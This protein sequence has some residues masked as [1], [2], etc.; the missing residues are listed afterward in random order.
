MVNEALR[1]AR[2]WASQQ[3]EIETSQ[4]CEIETNPAGVADTSTWT[5]GDKD[6]LVE[7]YADGSGFISFEEGEDDTKLIESNVDTDKFDV[8]PVTEEVPI[9]NVT[10]FAKK[11]TETR[12]LG[13]EI[14]LKAEGPAPTTKL[15]HQ[16]DTSKPSPSP[17]QI[18]A[19]RVIQET[20]RKAKIWEETQNKNRMLTSQEKEIGPNKDRDK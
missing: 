2:I 19:F 13:V 7:E 18:K 17:N 9:P 16:E 4:E 8:V 1:K 12:V 10:K 11:Q 14:V 6:F 15:E 5:I 3:K 20:L